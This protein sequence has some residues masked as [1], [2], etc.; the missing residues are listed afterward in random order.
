MCVCFSPSLLNIFPV[1][2]RRKRNEEK[3][4]IEKEERLFNVLVC[5]A[6]VYL[7]AMLI[8]KAVWRGVGGINFVAFVITLTFSSFDRSQHKKAEE[9]RRST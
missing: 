3:S 7:L 2:K 1:K 8:S 6:N 4:H 9:K 5:C